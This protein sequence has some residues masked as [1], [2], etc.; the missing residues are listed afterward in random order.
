MK[1][2]GVGGANAQM[3]QMRSQ[4][5]DPVSK[6]IQKQIEDLEDQLKE[7]SSDKKMSSEE[8]MQRRMELRKQI[9]DLNNQ[10]RQHQMEKQRE[11]QQ[12]VNAK[13][14]KA[15][16]KTQGADKAAAGI[17]QA[18][19]QALI[20]A[21][22]SM[23]QARVTQ[24]TV[25]QLEGRAGVLEME[26]K[27]NAGGQN[28]VESKEKQLQKTKELAKNATA[29]QMNILKKANEGME[30]AAKAA[31]QHTDEV[32]D[33]QEKKGKENILSGDET[34]FSKLEDGKNTD[35]KNAKVIM[36]TRDGKLVEEETE[37]TIS[38]R[39]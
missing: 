32:S 38:V 3:G 35:S 23:A 20:S 14:T 11:N 28:A 1:I 21:D 2:G 31:D 18:G 12:K 39:A 4:T 13:L 7:I 30:E 15:V 27:S 29:S 22:A 24:K 37:A 17:T 5:T 36:Y 19:M 26:M 10:L 6:N 9:S 33:T 16:D 8:K 34:N 25:K